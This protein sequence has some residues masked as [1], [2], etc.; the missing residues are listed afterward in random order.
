MIGN[1]L[2]KVSNAFVLLRTVGP[3]MFFEQLKRHIYSRHLQIVLEKDLEEN[4]VRARN[5]CKINYSLR[6]ATKE[7]MDEVLYKAKTESKEAVQ[8][9]LHR[10]WL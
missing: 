7:D 9:L 4:N 10:K 2:R 1:F 8:M 3:N 6:L 5:E